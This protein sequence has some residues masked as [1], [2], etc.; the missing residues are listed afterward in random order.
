MARMKKIDTA[1]CD[2]KG[3]RSDGSNEKDACSDGSD[4]QGACGPALDGGDKKE[5][6]CR[7]KSG[8]KGLR[9][10]AAMNTNAAAGAAGAAAAR[11]VVTAACV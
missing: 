7:H 8:H 2:E 5:N 3:A 1:A 10:I 11:K 9:V 6:C 4:Q